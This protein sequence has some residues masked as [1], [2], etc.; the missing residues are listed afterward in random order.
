MITKYLIKII[1]LLICLFFGVW[2]FNHI[3]PWLGIGLITIIFIISI[4]YIFKQLEKF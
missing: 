3:H 1:I 2:I 4:D